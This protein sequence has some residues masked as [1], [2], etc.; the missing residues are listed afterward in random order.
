MAVFDLVESSK[1][2]SRKITYENST[3][4]S[5]VWK[6][7]SGISWFYE[8]A[9]IWHFLVVF[10]YFWEMA[11]LSR[12]S[13]LYLRSCIH[14]VLIRKILLLFNFIAFHRWRC[15]RI[16]FVT[17]IFGMNKTIW[18]SYL[19]HMNHILVNCH[20]ITQFLNGKWF[21]FV[22]VALLLHI[23]IANR[24]RK[25]ELFKNWFH[26][27]F[28]TCNWREF[29]GHFICE[30]ERTDSP[31]VYLSNVLFGKLIDSRVLIILTQ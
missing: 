29:F 16:N 27:K 15:N 22:K 20:K 13:C 10:G 5:K 12:Y 17:S 14:G 11:K 9:R 19:A 1:L 6:S 3:L 7:S 24:L 26:T 23:W 30:F 4:L 2:I 8:V 21:D 31:E 25:D 18:T 28:V